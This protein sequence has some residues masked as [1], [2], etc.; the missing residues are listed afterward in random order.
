MIGNE[1]FI[2]DFDEDFGFTTVHSD[3]LANTDEVEKYKQRLY[4]LRK[5]IMPFLNNLMKNPEN[6]MIVWPN[7]EKKIKEFIKKI[8]KIVEG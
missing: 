8:D 4:A 5:A 6:D 2:E 3:T 7:R 1:S